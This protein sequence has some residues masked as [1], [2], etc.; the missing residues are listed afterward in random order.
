MGPKAGCRPD[1]K[2]FSKNVEEST[3]ISDIHWQD[4]H[5][6]NTEEGSNATRAVESDFKKSN[7][8]RM[9]KSF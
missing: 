9:P 1:F 3:Y 5:E 2:V 8:S 4:L 7:K 6:N